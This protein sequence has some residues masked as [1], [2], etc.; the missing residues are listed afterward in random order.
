MNSLTDRVPKWVA[1]LGRNQ[2]TA[3]PEI[4]AACI[5]CGRCSVHC[6]PQAMTVIDGKVH[7]D[8]DKCIRCYCCQELC[9]EDLVH[10]AEGR[11]LKLARRLVYLN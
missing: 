4:D 7:I 6:P 9:P 11:L 2:L 5:G 10:L 1:D 8:Y 3:R